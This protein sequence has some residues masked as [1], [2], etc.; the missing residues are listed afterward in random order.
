[1]SQIDINA[2][3]FSKK[4][5]FLKKT[6]SG[7]GVVIMKEIKLNSRFYFG[8]MEYAFCRRSK[9]AEKFKFFAVLPLKCNIDY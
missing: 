9:R 2:A 4:F 3:F 6:L 1:M 7:H 5:G 8:L